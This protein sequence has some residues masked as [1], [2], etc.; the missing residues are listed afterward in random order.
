VQETLLLDTCAVIW[1]SS[2]EAEITA[3]AV[4]ALGRAQDA[5]DTIY[6]SPMTAWEI[7]LLVARGRLSLLMSPEL[8]FS[9]F[10]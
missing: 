1:I 4:D 3:E 9:Q 6:V 8:D 10:G 2:E 7:G 5:G